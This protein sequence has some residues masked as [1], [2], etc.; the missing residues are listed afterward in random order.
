MIKSFAYRSQEIDFPDF[1]EAELKELALKFPCR[2]ELFHSNVCYGVERNWP[3]LLFGQS[4][5]QDLRPHQKRQLIRAMEKDG[6][7]LYNKNVNGDRL[8]RRRKQQTNRA[9]AEYNEERFL[10][11]RYIRLRA[12]GDT[13]YWSD[14]DTDSN[15]S[16]LT[17]ID[18]S[19]LDHATEMS[20]PPS[21]GSAFTVQ[22]AKDNQITQSYGELSS[23][24]AIASCNNKTVT[25]GVLTR[26]RKK[27]AAQSKPSYHLS[28][29]RS[30][31]NDDDIFYVNHTDFVAGD[32]SIAMLVEIANHNTQNDDVECEIKI[33]EHIDITHDDSSN[34]NIDADSGRLIIDK[35]YTDI[36]TQRPHSLVN[37][38]AEKMSNI[39]LPSVNSNDVVRVESIDIRYKHGRFNESMELYLSHMN[40]QIE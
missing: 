5:Y 14:S 32:D 35:T 15:C 22:F 1:S 29:N 21:S 2:V 7:K 13:A 9:L 3:K 37:D 18:N 30:H 25:S 40:A 12:L 28:T 10:R 6:V 11:N 4:K 19:G 31:V 27:T 23:A 33:V 34:D 38:F 17:V 36:L 26:S 16:I 39:S 8:R 20:S 24:K